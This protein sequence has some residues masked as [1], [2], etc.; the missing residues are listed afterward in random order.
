MSNGDE[1]NVCVC[2]VNALG[3]LRIAGS[4]DGCSGDE[5]ANQPGFLG[6]DRLRGC[7]QKADRESGRVL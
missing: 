2:V 6:S 4:P 1:L 3:T 5:F 7:R